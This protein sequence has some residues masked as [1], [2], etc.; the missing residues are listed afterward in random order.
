M[1]FCRKTITK[2]L[3][4]KTKYLLHVNLLLLAV[5]GGQCSKHRVLGIVHL[6]NLSYLCTRNHRYKILCE[7]SDQKVERINSICLVMRWLTVM[8]SHYFKKN[9]N[10]LNIQL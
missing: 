6:V 3:L 10:L 7:Q 8:V 9:N 4:Y 1:I 5:T 2:E